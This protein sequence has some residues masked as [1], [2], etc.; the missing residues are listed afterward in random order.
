MEEEKLEQLRKEKQAREREVELAK[1]RERES[2]A[3]QEQLKETMRAAERAKRELEKQKVALE[4]Q[5]LLVSSLEKQFGASS[6]F[7]PS[8]VADFE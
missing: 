1:E 6:T 5:N 2:A 8:G 3:Q 4:E 7:R